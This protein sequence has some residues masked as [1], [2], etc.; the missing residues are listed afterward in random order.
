[1][2]EILGQSQNPSIIQLHL[3][4][5]FSGI[6]TV[7]FTDQQDRILAMRSHL[8]EE[9]PLSEDIEVGE[10][11]E[12]WLDE[13]GKN[14]VQTLKKSTQAIKRQSLLDTFESY[15]SQVICLFN[16]LTFNAKASAAIGRGRGELEKLKEEMQGLLSALTRKCHESKSE[17]VLAKIK[18]LIL[19]LI[20]QISIVEFL[21]ANGVSGTSEW[22][23][24]KQLKIVEEQAGMKLNM[25]NATFDYTFEYQ[26]NAQKLV[27]T[28][29]TDKC[30]LTLTQAMHM[31]LGGNPYGPAGTG[32][33][34]SVK[35]LAL[36]FGRQV[37]VFNCD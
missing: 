1:M 29:L 24:S 13:L 26:G 18:S 30:Y 7:K 9:V 19:D 22:G 14:M 12:S 17:L 8:R 23:W 16:E 35:A 31:G 2:L 5:L 37:L 32:K 25:A 36:A 33:T 15:C 11:V 3:K 28:P 4:K 27:Y 10:V 6:H 21:I 34:E 20:H